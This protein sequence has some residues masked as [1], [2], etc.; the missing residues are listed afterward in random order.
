MK[1]KM[2]STSRMQDYRHVPA[3][4]VYLIMDQI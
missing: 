2:A 4:P 3:H 1:P